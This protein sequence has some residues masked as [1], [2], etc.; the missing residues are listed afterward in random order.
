MTS[1]PQSCVV[2]G[3]GGFLG[4][5]LCR[6]LVAAGV[7]V[8]AFGRTRSFPDALKGMEWREGSFGDTGALASAVESCDVVFH[9]IHAHMPQ[10]AN[11]N[12]AEDIRQSV[13]PSLALLDIARRLGVGRIVFVSSG[14][15]VYGAA[16]DIPTPE[17]AATDP[18]TAYGIGKL[19]IEK[20]LGLYERLYGLSFRV[21]RVANPFGPFQLPDKGQG[22]IATLL[23]RALRG[24]PIE[25]W[26]DGS[27]VRD[28]VYVDDVIDALQAASV[29]ESS[30]RV[31]NV[32][33]GR[34]YSVRE[35][36][37][38]VEAQLGKKL[39]VAWKQGRP[40]DVP[41][42]I[43]SIARSRDLLGW[44]P[45]TSFEDGLRRTIEWWR[46]PSLTA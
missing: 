13:I 19:T 2:L 10:T 17:S 29:D 7:R 21:L 6:R 30:G 31:F 27:V 8:R 36:I 34:G 20:Y 15:T 46:S 44:N 42:S 45:R 26:G 24:E 38:A 14:G 28:Y 35:V 12:M 18:I 4:T 11:L 22:L 5:N 1:A 43:L 32:G 23:S 41:V 3:G 37:A 9:L 39:S 40:I 33:S 16:K 25:I